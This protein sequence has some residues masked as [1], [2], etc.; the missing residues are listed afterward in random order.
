[1]AHAINFSYPAGQGSFSQPSHQDSNG[2]TL[3]SRRRYTLKIHIERSKVLFRMNAKTEDA[4][5]DILPTKGPSFP[6]LTRPNLYISD[7]SPFS[8]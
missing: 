2:L 5:V 8:G 1:M 7:P 3:N 6:N 4:Q